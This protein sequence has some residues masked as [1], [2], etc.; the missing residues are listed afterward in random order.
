MIGL[1]TLLQFALLACSSQAGWFSRGGTEKADTKNAAQTPQAPAAERKTKAPPPPPVEELA[2]ADADHTCAAGLVFDV[3][4]NGASADPVRVEMSGGQCETV[5]AFEAAVS[6][7]V[8]EDTAAC[9]VRDGAGRRVRRCS[10]L[11]RNSAEAGVQPGLIPRAYGVRRDMRFV[12]A[13][14]EVGFK[15]Y[16][17]HLQITLTTLAE[18]PRLFALDNFLTED[19]ASQ[20]IEDALA[21]QDDEHKLTRASVGAKGYTVSSTRT[22]ETVWESNF[23]RPTPSTRRRPSN[24]ICSMA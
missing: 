17:P 2:R 5:A 22:S 6:R 15:R 13:T 11:S 19:D 24:C 10:E 4:K 8:C 18:E 12:F 3:Y 20:L 7:A 21:I 9:H 1:R 16:L 23:G 14:E